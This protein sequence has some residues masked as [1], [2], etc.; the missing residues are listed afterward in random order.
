MIHGTNTLADTVRNI[1]RS[2]AGGKVA[3]VFPGLWR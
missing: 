2:T 1:P 3:H